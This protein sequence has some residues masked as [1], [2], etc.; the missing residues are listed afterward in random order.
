M[1]IY[2]CVCH[3]FVKCMGVS[4]GIYI[5]DLL[6]ECQLR[7]HTIPCVQCVEYK[8]SWVSGICIMYGCVMLER[9]YIADVFYVIRICNAHNI[10][11]GHTLYYIYCMVLRG[12][13]NNNAYC[14]W[15]VISPIS[16]RNVR[17]SPP[18]LFCHVLVTRDQ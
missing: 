4:A 1:Y 5:A 10:L 3:Q 17:S 7:H 16:I 12:H 14:N 18:G 11:M 15:S 8:T 9:G 6:S 13:A 2:M